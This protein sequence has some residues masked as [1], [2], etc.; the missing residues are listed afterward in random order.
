MP[1]KRSAPA[2]RKAAATGPRLLLVEDSDVEAKVE[3]H[4][5]VRDLKA[6]VVRVATVKAALDQP[7]ET[8]EVVV[9]DYQLPDGNGLQ[10]LRDFHAKEP[11]VPV[12]FVTGEG[13]EEVAMEALSHG[14]QDYLVK[15]PGLAKELPRR[16]RAIL[17]RAPEI[18]DA[19]AMV[20]IAEE[21]GAAKPRAAAA[22][23]AVARPAPGADPVVRQAI[24]GLVKGPVAGAALFGMDG[25]AL[26]DRLPPGADATGLGAGLIGVQFQAQQALRHVP[27]AGAP[28]MVLAQWGNGLVAAAAVPGPALVV[29]LLKPEASADEAQEQ[30]RRAVQALWGGPS[31]GKG[32]SGSA[33]GS[34]SGGK[35]RKR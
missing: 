29:L 20:R 26:V 13:S 11:G 12:L 9:L 3:Q 33:G 22:S 7:L 17:E 19:A 8:F 16:V 24:E 15:G 32:G 21:G 14:A 35:K 27:S 1:T 31:A 6:E 2:P 30:L 28:S 34:G 25:K 23:A 18:A 5:L 10:V 4:V